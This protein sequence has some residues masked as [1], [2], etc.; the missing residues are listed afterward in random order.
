MDDD[1]LLRSLTRVAREVERA[2]KELEQELA[3]GESTSG[4]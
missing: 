1:D 4:V 2:V 3:R